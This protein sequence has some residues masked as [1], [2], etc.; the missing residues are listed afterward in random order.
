MFRIS[1]DAIDFNNLKPTSSKEATVK[2]ITIREEPSI[3]MV[4]L[5]YIK[6]KYS[7]FFKLIRYIICN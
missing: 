3:A 7:K 4:R 6:K 2:P 5:K 1:R